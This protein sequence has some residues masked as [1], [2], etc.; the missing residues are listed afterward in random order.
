VVQLEAVILQIYG[1]CFVIGVFVQL[2]SPYVLF[3]HYEV[4]K[5]SLI[6]C[7]VKKYEFERYE[8]L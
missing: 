4:G 5:K 6:K 8:R 3:Y 1:Y 7:F 2:V